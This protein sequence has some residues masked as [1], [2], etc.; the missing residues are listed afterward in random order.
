MKKEFLS[1]TR[2]AALAAFAVLSAEDCGGGLNEADK[3][4]ILDSMAKDD[5]FKGRD[6]V[7]G[8]GGGAGLD[9]KGIVAELKKSPESDLS[10]EIKARAS[11]LTIAQIEAELTK[12]AAEASTLRDQ[13]NA[14]ITAGLP[15]AQ[16][17]AT[18]K[19]E[20][21]KLT[22]TGVADRLVAFDPV[23]IA[24][25]GSNVFDGV[26]A[27][28]LLGSPTFAHVVKAINALTPDPA[29]RLALVGKV[30]N[31]GFTLVNVTG[32]AIDTTTVAHTAWSA[33]GGGTAGRASQ[34]TTNGKYVLI[35]K[36]NPVLYLHTGANTNATTDAAMQK[37]KSDGT[38]DGTPVTIKKA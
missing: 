16:F 22:A 18:E 3:K 21:A 38:G 30:K 15:A 5:R 24:L 26:I 17:S 20:L 37:A 9:A 13:V 8:E 7:N 29:V 25:A 28:S 11:G 34:D 33:D 1:L 14:M 23:E 10:K 12:P 35:G 36:T 6:G 19:T 31:A 2:L 32:D 4:S 27:A